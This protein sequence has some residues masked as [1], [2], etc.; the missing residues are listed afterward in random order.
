MT[1]RF[2]LGG[3][4]SGKSSKAREFAGGK[5]KTVY[6]ATGVATDEDMESRISRHKEDRPKNWETIEEP[7]EIGEVLRNL[8]SRSFSGTVILDCLGFWLSNVLRELDEDRS[9]PDLED[10]L[11][12]RISEE[13]GPAGDGDFDL[14]VV[15]NVV[16]MGVIPGTAAGRKF[17]DVL[18]RV[19]QIVAET[20]DEV[21]LMMAGLSLQLK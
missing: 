7:V 20:A 19:N 4:R 12:E 14:I 21:Y 15:S 8:N 2:I 18:G 6:L 10:Y 5:G 16:G 1:T 11:G 9:G 17:R 13:L 3:A